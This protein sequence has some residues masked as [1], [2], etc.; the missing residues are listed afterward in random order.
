[1]D[2]PNF[3]YELRK[4]QRHNPM[5]WRELER[6]VQFPQDLVAV[7]N[8]GTCG[9]P[10]DNQYISEYEIY[11]DSTWSPSL[12]ICQA[13]VGSGCRS[14]SSRSNGILN[15]LTGFLSDYIPIS[16][17]PKP[18]PDPDPGYQCVP[19]AHCV[20]DRK[21]GE[22]IGTCHEE[23]SAVVEIITEPLRIL[24]NLLTKIVRIKFGSLLTYVIVTALAVFLGIPIG[25]P[26]F[27]PVGFVDSF[28]I[29]LLKI[30]IGI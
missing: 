24:V 22:G 10:K 13:K 29:F 4:E 21:A 17:D 11:V 16:H 19:G 6:S 14:R 26:P 30:E 9:C 15:S 7:C 20:Q 28:S 25:I 18:D 5:H 12:K 23:S 27:V 8:G 3:Q 2:L 1:M